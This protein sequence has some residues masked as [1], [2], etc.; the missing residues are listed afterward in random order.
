MELNLSNPLYSTTDNIDPSKENVYACL[1]F[2]LTI[3][4]Y[5]CKFQPDYSYGHDSYKMKRKHPDGGHEN[6]SINKKRRQTTIGL[7]QAKGKDAQWYR[8]RLCPIRKQNAW[9]MKPMAELPDGYDKSKDV[10]MYPDY[11]SQYILPVMEGDMLE[12]MLGDR[13]K[14]RPMARKVRVSQYSPRTCKELIE[15]IRK[16][17][18]NLENKKILGQIL[19]CTAMWRFL[20]SPVFKST[21]GL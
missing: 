4:L 5:F 2:I 19:P 14:T 8:G 7:K 9:F 11:I 17:I 3:F 12:F 1:R 20:G 15:Y 13:D 10:F 21:A 6:V 16:L 18:K